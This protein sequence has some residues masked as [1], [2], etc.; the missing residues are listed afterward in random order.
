MFVL[1][2]AQPDDHDPVRVV[3]Q[4][5]CPY[6]VLIRPW[7]GSDEDLT[8]ISQDTGQFTQ[9]SNMFITHFAT[10]ADVCVAG[11]QSSSQATR[12]DRGRDERPDEE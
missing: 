9:S 12:A 11:R 5:K 7:K 10:E 3:Q 6:V 1:R 4:L 8:G 2:V